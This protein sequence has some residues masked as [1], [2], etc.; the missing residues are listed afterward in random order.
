MEYFMQC[1][2]HEYISENEIPFSVDPWPW[3]DAGLFNFYFNGSKYS[4]KE[5]AFGNFRKTFQD[6]AAPLVG[7]E[8]L[9]RQRIIQKNLC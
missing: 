8:T 7:K 6:S 1:Q 3:M 5:R 2:W 9:A 4:P